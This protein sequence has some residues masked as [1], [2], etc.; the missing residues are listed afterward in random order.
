[1]RCCLK[2]NYNTTKSVPVPSRDGYTFSGWKRTNIYGTLSSLTSAAT[3]TYGAANGVTDTITAQW[4]CLHSWNDGEVTAS[5]TLTSTGTMTYTCAV[6]GAAREEDIPRLELPVITEQPVVAAVG[7]GQKASFHVAATGADSYQWQASSDGGNTWNN[8]GSSTAKTATLSVNATTATMRAVYRC[9]VT[10]ANGTV[11][12]YSVRIL[13]A[14]AAPVITAQPVNVRAIAGEK[15]TFYIAAAG[16]DTYQWQVS[17]DAGKTWKNSGSA[18]AVTTIL[19]LNVTAATSKVIYR[20]AVTNACGTTYSDSVRIT[21]TDI[22]PTITIQPVNAET[23]TGEKVRFTVTASRAETYQWQASSDNGKTWKNSGASGAAGATLSVNATAATSRAL[24]RCAV[25]NAW[26]T[27]YS[28]SVRITLTDVPP[29]ITVQPKNANS[30]TGAKAVF[31][32]SSVGTDS[33]QWQVSADNGKTWKNSGALSAKTPT[34]SVNVTAATSKVV[35]RCALTNENG[36]TY[37]NSV[38]IV[39]TDA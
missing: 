14:D 25:T 23:K 12:T 32:V 1:M 21:R 6:C 30:A 38:R 31:K 34:L 15:V 20:C 8:S 36:T 27:T 35:Y 4:E 29:V 26:G 37:T 28:D 5:P 33:W 3:Y 19:R 11:Y 22:S 39:L 17:S 16:A 9:A 24:Y 18:S 10:N 7:I 13:P 2:Q